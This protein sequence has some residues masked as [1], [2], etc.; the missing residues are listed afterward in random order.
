MNFPDDLADHIKNGAVGVIPTDT[1]FGIVASVHKPEALDKVYKAKERNVK[2]KLILLISSLNQL[3]EMGV[4]INDHQRRALDKLWP[5]P[6]SIE[7]VCDDTKPYLHKGTYCIAI[8]LPDNA[9]LR[10]LIDQTGPIVATSANKSGLPTPGTIEDIKQ[11][12]SGLDFYID[13]P[14]HAKPS[15]LAKILPDG[16]IEWLARS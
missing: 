12:I 4:H 13:G 6:V 1:I 11:Q 3:S 7:F 10:A 16:T 5:A 8:R 14:T 9:M 2:K 15:Q